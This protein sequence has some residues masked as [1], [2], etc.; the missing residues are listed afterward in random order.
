VAIAVAVAGL[1]GG[2][3]TTAPAAAGPPST[4]W[5]QLSTGAITNIENIGLARF[6]SSIQAVWVQGGTSNTA[7][8]RTRIVGSNGAPTSPLI[9]AQAGWE[10][11]NQFPAIFA[12]GKKRVIAF[13]GI[14]DTDSSNPYSEGVEYY[15][16]STNGKTWKLSTGALSERA[17][18]YSS[19]GTDGIDAGGKPVVGYTD[20][21]ADDVNFHEGFIATVPTTAGYEPATTPTVTCCT[22][23]T[24]LGYDMKAHQ[25]WAVWYSNSTQSATNGI[26]AQRIEPT[27]GGRSH[28]PG[29][30]VH[31]NSL[32]PS[33][34][35]VTAGRNS[36]GGVYAAYLVGY[37][38]AR[39][40]ALWKLGAKHAMLHAT[41]G[42]AER[43][44]TAAGPGGTMWLYWWN[45]NSHTIDVV[46]TTGDTVKFGPVC[47]VPTPNKTTDI[48]DLVGMGA[49]NNRTLHLFVLAG[50]HPQVYDAA[51]GPC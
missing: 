5:H 30:D 42:S 33:Q 18:A 39:K 16:T 9:A 4:H 49:A 8:L 3:A 44:G 35:I 21:S 14:Q 13:S 40:V 37:P 29:S 6:G 48:W 7:T 28:A 19:D 34:R 27:L 25:T 50:A 36:G 23:D 45:A 11:L 22:Y 51:V 32:D 2:L 41:G 24:G 1:T 15:V 10:S 26:L 12:S 46:K 43:V 17:T 47:Q 38:E 20:G 31:A